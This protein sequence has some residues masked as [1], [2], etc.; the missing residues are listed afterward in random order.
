VKRL[1]LPLFIAVCACAIALA[2][3]RPHSAAAANGTWSGTYYNTTTL[4][5]PIALSRDDGATLN[6]TWPGSPGPG[7]NAD[8][9][10]ASWSK[11]DTFTAGTF[12]FT[13]TADDGVRVYVDG[14]KIIDGWVDQNPTTY[15]A[16]YA[17][18]AGS[19]TIKVDYYDHLNGAQISVFIAPA[20]SNP[21]WLGQYW[22]NQN[23]SGL[24]VLTRTDPDVYFDWILASPGPGVPVD[25][26][27]AR[28]TSIINFQAGVYQF[29]TWSDDGA[30]VFVDGV[31]VL[32]FWV[33]QTVTTHTTFA[34]MTA[35][36]HTVVVEYYDDLY[37]AKMRFSYMFVP[38][39]GFVADT[40]AAG[41]DTPTAFAFAPDGRVFIAEKPGIVRVVKNGALLT[42]PFYTVPNVNNFHDRGLLGIALDPNFA[43]NGYVYLSYTY[44]NN[45]ANIG[46][47]KTDQIIR[48]TASGDT[49]LANSQFVLAG[50]VVGSAAQPSCENLPLTAD[51]IPTDGD[52]HSMGSLHFGPDGMLYAAVG[53]GASYFSVDP[54]A[55]RAQDVNRYPGKILRLNP[56]NGQ[57][58]PDN[59]FAICNPSCDLTSTRSKVW[60]LG[61]RNDFRFNFNPATGVIVSG[62]VGWDTWEELNR[63]AKGANLGWP[64]YEG[65]AQQPGYAAFAQCQSLY[66]AGGVTPPIYQYG[67]ANPG[68]EAAIGGGFTGTNNSYGVPFQNA[69]WFADYAQNTISVAKL[70]AS[71]QIL[72][73]SMSNITNSADG[74]V[75]LE[76][77]PNG[78]VYYLAINTG[79]LRHL[80]YYGGNRPPAAVA[81]SDKTAGTAPLTVQ[82]NGAASSDPDSN[83]ITY[84]WDFGDGTPHDTAVNPSHVYTVNGAYTARLTVSD[85]ALTNAATIAITVGNQPPTAT[86]T[87]PAAGSH[88]DIGDTITVTGTGFDPETGNLPP[89]NL[90]WSVVLNHC[91]DVTLLTCHT[92]PHLTATGASAT[93]L[94][95]DH[96]DFTSFDIFLT[97]TDGVL[98]TTTK[99]NISPNTVNATFTSN[100][101]GVSL[102]VDSGSQV[103]PFTHTVPRKSAHVICAPSPQTIGGTAYQF[104]AWSDGG[105]GCPS[106]APLHTITVTADTTYTATFVLA[107]TPTPTPTNTATATNTPLPTDTPIGLGGTL[108]PLPTDTPAPP[109]NT[110][111]PAATNT[112]VPPTATPV[113][114]TS[115]AVPTATNTPVP[116]TATP[117]PVPPTATN[118]PS[119]VPPTATNTPP[120]TATPVPPTSTAVPTA[121]D[122][123]APTATPIPPTDTPTSTAVPTATDTPVPP[124]AT[125]VPPTAT[126]T[127]VPPT[128]TDTPVPPTATNTPTAAQCAAIA[129]ADVSGD[130]VVAIDDLGKVALWF[131]QTVPPAPASYDQTGDN[132]ITIGDLGKQA[133]VFEMH[134]CA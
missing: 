85:G 50:S 127:P 46:A 100:Q 43:S 118:T 16:D 42:T 105:A 134:R 54:L 12:R 103:V 77:A 73:G 38:Q 89:A 58:L 98:T 133:L 132:K 4:S 48:V 66:S 72:A 88:Y 32:N 41:L 102:T 29:T 6:F 113:P 120:P 17:V 96:G 95:T 129:L 35:G 1:Q 9:W 63:I 124:T 75:D 117:T 64:C 131:G 27:S 84:D 55:L 49:A 13:A 76:T 115:T 111:V 40:V 79:E 93:F 10:S 7:V 99:I 19:H 70:D 68:G 28:W 130:G 83:P 25:N 110:A 11:T 14:T 97:A 8:S 52:S 86:I 119:P 5:G 69:Y 71:D 65:V 109:T 34:N 125:P 51:C 114:P 22:S 107:P 20:P 21:G 74:P 67:H 47:A 57:G 106:A 128:A 126:D 82:F 101:A 39:G 26:W 56:Q 44:D 23:L 60:A 24:P 90:A 15:T 123:P 62:D 80:T 36:P 81:T 87:S 122:T 59:P 31:P 2:P 92:H 30:R 3:L 61:V 104:S 33:D 91:T 116:P 112:P 121:T 94:V 18:T 37:D 108:T 78:D 45:P 53:D